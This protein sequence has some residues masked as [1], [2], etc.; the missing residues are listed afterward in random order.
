MPIYIECILMQKD[1]ATVSDE[2]DEKE[3][4]A[5]NL[6]TDQVTLSEFGAWRPS[7]MKT[8]LRNRLVGRKVPFCS[9]SET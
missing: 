9:S 1:L 2:Q 8:G 7:R 4:Q 5:R 3:H 6:P